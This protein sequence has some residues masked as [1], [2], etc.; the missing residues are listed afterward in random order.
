M[1]RIGTLY[2]C[3]LM[4]LSMFGSYC[5]FNGRITNGDGDMIPVHEAISNAMNSPWWSDFK[6]SL[7]ET[8][9]QVQHRGYYET[10]KMIVDQ[11]DTDGEK[12]AFKVYAQM[13]FTGTGN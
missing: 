1:R 13:I 3:G 11:M 6:Q 9:A 8:Y 4:Y 10:W 7:S 2:I 12:N 5:Y